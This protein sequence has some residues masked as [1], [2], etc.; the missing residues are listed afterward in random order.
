MSDGPHRSLPMR[1][2]WKKVAECGANH[3][4]A[5]EQVSQR[6]APALEEDCRDELPP[7]FT[8]ALQGRYGSLFRNQLETDLESLRDLA[9]HGIG[10]VILDHAIHLAANGDTGTDAPL[11]AVNR[12]LMD[13][14]QR[15][16][17]QVEEHYL[18]EASDRKAKHVRAR[19]DDGIGQAAP[20]VEA[21]ARKILKIDSGSN[22]KPQKQD[23]L[24]DGVRF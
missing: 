15:C 19:I 12:A 14:A 4:F 7:G 24:D 16:S 10:R 3:A 20:V 22:S 6:I 9:G 23:G 2:G 13:R 21:L 1:R 18:R 8:D 17:R 11:K 5:P